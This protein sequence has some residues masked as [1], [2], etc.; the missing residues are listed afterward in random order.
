MNVLL[1]SPPFDRKM[2][3]NDK[4][5]RFTDSSLIANG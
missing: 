2:Q 5:D 4:Q 3:N 1:E